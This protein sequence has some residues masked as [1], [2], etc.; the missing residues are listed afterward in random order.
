[1]A[2]GLAGHEP[3]RPRRAFGAIRLGPG[4]SWRAVRWSALQDSIP[5]DRWVAAE[6]EALLA[7]GPELRAELRRMRAQRQAGTLKTV[8]TASVRA[9]V[10]AA[11][12]KARAGE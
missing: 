2:V 5:E 1:M 8:D 12:R 9:A 3:D 6:A 10:D 7:A 11:A 4:A